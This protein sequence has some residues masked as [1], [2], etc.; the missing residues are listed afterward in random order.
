MP[1]FLFLFITS[2]KAASSRVCLEKLGRP[3]VG[4]KCTYRSGQRGV[5]TRIMYG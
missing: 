3:V 4:D 2:R 5:I 1:H